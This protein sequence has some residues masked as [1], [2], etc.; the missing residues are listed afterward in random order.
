MSQRSKRK[1]KR[2]RQ[3]AQ[4]KPT[5][6]VPN[7]PSQSVKTEIRALELLGL[8]LT[9]L[10]LISLIGLRPRPSVFSYLPAGN[11]DIMSSRFTVT[12][13]GYLQ[14]N[15]VRAICFVWKATGSRND[16]FYANLSIPAYPPDLILPPGQSFTVPCE[17]KRLSNAQ[18]KSAD[19][20]IVVSYRP[21][22]FIFMRERKFFRFVARFD[23]GTAAWDSQPSAILEHDFDR[24]ISW[25]RSLS[26]FE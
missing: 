13:E 25:S 15:D 8:L 24:S 17:N 23:N 11:S 19:L 5:T 1:S 6:Q 18:Y 22:P 12:N 10:G 4:P 21:W 16:T 2:K 3:T 9:A 7:T 20:A 26:A 14:L